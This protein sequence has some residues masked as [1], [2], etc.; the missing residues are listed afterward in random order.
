MEPAGGVGDDEVRAAGDGRVQRVVDDGAGVGARRVGDDRHAGA[1]RPD[2]EL[3]DGGGAERVGGGEDDRS[4]LRRVAAGELAD[5]RG[6]AGPVDADDEDD[7]RAPVDR[8]PRRP[9]EVARDEQRAELGA[10]RGLGAARVAAPAGALDDIHREGRADVAGDERLLD[11]V[12][13]RAVVPRRGSRG[14]A[15]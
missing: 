10:D 8:R 13:R 14:A 2:P 1:V 9:V 7:R 6:L 5:R 4:P 15:S 11:V 12:P 3:V